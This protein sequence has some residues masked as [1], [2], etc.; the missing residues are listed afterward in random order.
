MSDMTIMYILSLLS[1]NLPV[2]LAIVITCL[3]I[4]VYTLMG[5]FGRRILGWEAERSSSLE[6]MD[7]R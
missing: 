4:Y 7:G 1:E 5:L 6:G 2:Q 3:C